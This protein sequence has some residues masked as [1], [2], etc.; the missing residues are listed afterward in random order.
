[1]RIQPAHTRSARVLS[2]RM[3]SMRMLSMRILFA[4]IF[5]ACMLSLRRRAYRWSVSITQSMVD[6]I[7]MVEIDSV[8]ALPTKTIWRVRKAWRAKTSPYDPHLTAILGLL[9]VLV[10]LVYPA[11][12][13]YLVYFVVSVDH[14]TFTLS[15]DGFIVLYACFMFSGIAYTRNVLLSGHSLRKVGAFRM[16][17]KQVSAYACS[18]E[19]KLPRIAILVPARNEG[20][21]IE[22]TVRRLIKLDYPKH[23][24]HIVIITDERELDDSVE[25]L[26][27]E[28]VARVAAEANAEFLTNFVQFVEVP[29]WYSGVFGSAKWTFEKSTKGRALNF[30]LQAISSTQ[31]WNEIDYL[32]VVDAD[33]RLHVD[34][35][36][37]MAYKALHDH[38]QVLQGPVFQVSNISDVSLVGRMAAM[39]LALHHLTELLPRCMRGQFQ[40]LAGTNYFVAKNAIVTCGG[41][42]QYALVE[43][44][45][46]AVRLYIQS[47]VTASWLSCYELEQTPQNFR[48][49]RRQRERWVRGHLDLLPL[50][51]RSALPLNERLTFVGSVLF[52]QFRFVIDSGFPI[53]ALLYIM[54]ALLPRMNVALT[55]MM[56][57]FLI[58]SFLIWDIYGLTYRRLS[59]FFSTES[60]TP[61][62]IES[63]KLFLFAP[64]MMV[65]QAVPRATA[66]YKFVFM[67]KQN[68]W[69]KTE[70]TR[71]LVVE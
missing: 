46:L 12:V 21:V 55:V 20:Y 36:K 7:S 71:E 23:L 68:V 22:N 38:A 37:E 5:S 30:A 3:L 53:I 13:A 11:F 26:T 18:R 31:L 35:L 54:F 70:R 41:W 64:I 65:M 61:L 33:G 50:I 67:S 40:F 4:C 59:P 58:F 57:S 42:D 51:L 27:K 56:V 48:V 8:I 63:V 49:Y 17:I 44:A 60:K 2:M 32:G 29:K 45:E 6:A 47:H 39:E 62:L 52:A 1:M 34:V 24:Y 16:T 66:L 43:D 15:I 10:C 69:Y 9:S 25:R 28:V 19:M 14:D